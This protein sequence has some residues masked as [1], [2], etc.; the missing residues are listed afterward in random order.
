MAVV[1]KGVKNGVVFVV[2]NGVVAVVGNGVV[3]MVLLFTQL[4]DLNSFSSL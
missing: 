2:G 4:P 3:S 1:G